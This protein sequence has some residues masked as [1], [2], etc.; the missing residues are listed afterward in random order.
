MKFSRYKPFFT[1]WFWPSNHIYGFTKHNCYVNRDNSGRIDCIELTIELD[2][3]SN[4]HIIP[5][6]GMW[7]LRGYE[8]TLLKVRVADDWV[9]EL[10]LHIPIG[11]FQEYTSGYQKRM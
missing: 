10:Y 3:Y 6:H 4:V 1:R 7:T 8:F 2:Q 11:I 5:D 9:Y